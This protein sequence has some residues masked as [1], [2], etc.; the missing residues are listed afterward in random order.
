MHRLFMSLVVL[1]IL[2]ALLPQFAGKL[3]SRSEI[4]ERVA[5]QKS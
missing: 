1:A 4:A 5:R 2:T 3:L